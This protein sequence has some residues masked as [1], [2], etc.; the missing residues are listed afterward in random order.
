MPS[1]GTINL[2]V[3]STKT[4]I[5]KVFDEFNGDLKKLVKDLHEAL[6]MLESFADVFT[7]DDY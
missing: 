6:I 2:F 4:N 5:C 3:D 7:K 1:P